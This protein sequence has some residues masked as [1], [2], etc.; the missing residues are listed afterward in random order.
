MND[1]ADMNSFRRYTR[2]ISE[3]R[4]GTGE[5]GG[6]TVYGE[7]DRGTAALAV[8]DDT[9]HWQLM[10]VPFCLWCTVV[11]Q[12]LKQSPLVRCQRSDVCDESHFNVQPVPLSRSPS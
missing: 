2:G 5:R 11:E 3:N 7:I 10:Q 8:R 12:P 9:Y 1:D 4:G 6:T